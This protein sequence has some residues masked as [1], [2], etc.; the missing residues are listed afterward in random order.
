MDTT[1]I[2]TQFVDLALKYEQW[3]KIEDL[4]REEVEILLRIVKAASFEARDVVLG[5]LTGNYLD[6]EGRKTVDT[7]PINSFCPFKVVS[8]EGNDEQ[9]TSWLDYVL[10]LVVTKVEGKVKTREQLIEMVQSSINKAIPLE[11]IRLTPEGDFL[12]EDASCASLE[13]ARIHHTRD[14]QL[15]HSLV[16]VHKHCGGLLDRQRA[17]TTSDVLVCR[18]CY[19]RVA[20]PRE[21]ETYGDLRQALANQQKGASV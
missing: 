4:P 21:V 10:E 14:N 16:G 11:P 6:Q 8:R 7:Y 1:S 12:I 2:A 19:L 15:L 20:F 3:G 17:T 5:K 18:K 13:P 9:A